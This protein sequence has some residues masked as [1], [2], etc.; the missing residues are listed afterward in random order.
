MTANKTWSAC[1]QIALYHP[2]HARA[3][4]IRLPAAQRLASGAEVQ[5]GLELEQAMAE[6]GRCFSC[7]TCTE[8]D[9][10]FYYCPDLAISGWSKAG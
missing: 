4:E 6:A 2:A 1:Q 10:C 9:N 8:C 5:L 3:A 7:G